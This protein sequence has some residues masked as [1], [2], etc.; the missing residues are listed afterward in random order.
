MLGVL[1]ARLGKNFF[2]D[3]WL[4]SQPAEIYGLDVYL[5]SAGWLILWCALLLWGF[6]SRLRRGLRHQIDGLA[7]GWKTPKPAEGIFAR[8]E[9]D[10]RRVHR[11]RHDLDRLEAHVATLRRRLALPDEQLGRRR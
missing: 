10:C 5:L 2:Y 7:E 6:T 9:S 11:F 4:A 1:I 3:S 8:L